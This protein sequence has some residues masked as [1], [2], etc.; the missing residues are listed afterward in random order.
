M[1][2]K[3]DRDLLL[4]HNYDGIQEY[5]NPLPGW[6]SGLF[7]GTIVFSALY[8]LYHHSGVEGRSVYDDY[9]REKAEVFEKRFAE[10]GELTPDKE[11]ILKY[12]N[13]PK[14]LAVGESVFK[15]NCVSC[16]A[17]GGLGNVGPNLTDDYWKN[18]Q[19]VED[20][21]KVIANGAA[22]GA[23]PAWKNRLSHPNQI[24]LTAAYVASLRGKGGGGGKPPEGRK[25]PPWQ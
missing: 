9:E 25:I 2:A 3:T 17:D 7:V 23:M 21:A 15:A 14:W 10:L 8:L 24:V 22:G 4:D 11:T 12:M 13:D 1:N 19:S 18:V 16:H 5:D 20:I 6:W